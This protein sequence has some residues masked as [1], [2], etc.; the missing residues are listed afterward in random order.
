MRQF[1]LNWVDALA[2]WTGF[3]GGWYWDD[4]GVFRRILQGQR[5]KCAW[6]YSPTRIPD[7][8]RDCAYLHMLFD[9][10]LKKVG[11]VPEFCMECYKVVVYPRDLADV[12]AIENW[13]QN[14]EAAGWACKV[15]ADRRPYTNH[16][17][18]AYFYCRGLEEARSRYAKVAAW[19]DENLGDD[20][21][22]IIK[23]GCTEYENVFHDSEQWRT[24]DQSL[25][26]EA[27]A[28]MVID[29]GDSPCI[30]PDVL[31][32]DTYHVWREHAAAIDRETVTYHDE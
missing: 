12:G 6:R 7:R 3:Q 9:A 18:G 4:L 20:V 25:K 22:V 28:E 1:L 14:G 2:P 31:G 10:A 13:Q 30:Q 19:V 11:A 24:T 17:W 23:R 5:P 15:G 26:I 27:E 21:E 32:F 8:K 16:F 29:P